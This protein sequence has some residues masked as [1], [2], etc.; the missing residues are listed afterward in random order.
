VSPRRTIVA[1]RRRRIFGVSA[2][3][4]VT[5]LMVALIKAGA[6]FV[7]PRIFLARTCRMTVMLSRSADKCFSSRLEPFF[8]N[9]N[10]RKSQDVGEAL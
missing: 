4:P 3:A 10:I 5:L 7:A 1:D 9:E 6:Y 2:G 8:R